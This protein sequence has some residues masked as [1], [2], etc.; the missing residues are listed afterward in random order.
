MHLI[1]KNKSLN[2]SDKAKIKFVKDRPGHD[3]RY[4]LNNRKIFKELGWKAKISLQLGLDQTFNWYLNNK[5]YFNK[6]SK[7]LY[8]NRLGLKL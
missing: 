6:I 5:T 8:I 7:K 4:A 1:A 2:N 3:I